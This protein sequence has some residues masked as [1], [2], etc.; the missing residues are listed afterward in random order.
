MLTFLGPAP[1]PDGPGVV[2]SPLSTRLEYGDWRTGAQERR[3]SPYLR[4]LY[5]PTA[6]QSLVSFLP[7][8]LRPYL[9]QGPRDPFS[10]GGRTGYVG[11][12]TR[13][14]GLETGDSSPV[15]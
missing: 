11:T 10:W 5:T 4:P 6:N 15:V 7:F 3:F 8:V 14:K 13:R 2:L 9:G 12:Q 1:S